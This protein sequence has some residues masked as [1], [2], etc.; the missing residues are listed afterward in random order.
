MGKIARERGGERTAIAAEYGYFSEPGTCVVFGMICVT[1]R[2]HTKAVRP[3]AGAKVP[4]AGGMGQ[5]SLP[6]RGYD[7]RSKKSYELQ[8]I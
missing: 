8:M 6:A 3:W 7:F 2:I 5:L 4:G 1:T